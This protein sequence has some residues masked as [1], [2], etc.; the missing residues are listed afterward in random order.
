MTL[1]HCIQILRERW[2]VIVLVALVMMSAAGGLWYVRPSEYTAKVTLYVSAQT[3]DTAQSAY[4]GAQLSQQ[5]VTSY[6]ELVTSARVAQD[7]L[8]QIG[9]TEDP[10]DLVKKIKASS[11]AD[12]VLI[13][14][15][16]VDRSPQRAADIANAVAR[17]FA[18]LVDELER[19]TVAG[20]Q[21]PVAVRVVQPAAPSV[22]PSSAGLLELLLLGLLAGTVLGVGAALLRNALDRQVKSPAHLREAVNAP[23]LG[24]VT[25]DPQV[26]KRPLTVHEDPQSPRSEAFRQLR[27]N[28]QFVDVDRPRKAIVVTSSMP[29]E[30]KTTSLANLAIALASAGNDVLVVE[31]DLRR[32]K[33]ADLLGLDRSI[34][35]TNVLAGRLA[36]THA[37]QHWSAGVDVLASGPLPPNPSELLA[38]Q[39][40]AN[41]LAEMRA[42]Y[43]VILIDTPPLLPVTDA[44]AVAPATDGVLLV[45][46]FKETS[47]DQVAM[48]RQA[49]D[50]VGAQVLGTIFTMVPATGPRAYGQYNAY[51]RTEV[52]ARR[53][54]PDAD[55]AGRAA[56]K[57][58]R[59][60][61]PPRAVH[62]PLPR[63]SRAAD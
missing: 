27:T 48:A 42:A 1:E 14:V 23:N 4:Q 22:R 6:V 59:T 16:V 21:P 61:P 12:S 54:A 8:R 58:R 50:A 39:Q 49:L 40:M 20:A 51:Y 17:V 28:L 34:G 29:S 9:S 37:I 46:R 25:F 10:T 13:D 57:G 11:A 32:P 31:A 53:P 38:S 47:R 43:D 44:A 60:V 45:C 36:A 5:R 15:E 56:P 52:P 26:P 7:V 3:A 30:G 55:P 35:L 33:L 41:L 63:A 2:R 62:T 24:T 19:P 18:S